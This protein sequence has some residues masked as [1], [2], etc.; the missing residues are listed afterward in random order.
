MGKYCNMK[1][2]FSQVT[3]VVS[4]TAEEKTDLRRP[5]A[6]ARRACSSFLLTLQ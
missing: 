3:N 2:T 6:V 4:Q 5:E 1:T